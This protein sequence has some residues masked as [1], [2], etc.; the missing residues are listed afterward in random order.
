MID[1]NGS[2]GQ[3][4]LVNLLTRARIT[5]KSLADSVGIREATVSDWKNRG[6][7]PS[8]TPSQLWLMKRALNATDEELIEA[9]EGF[10]V[11]QSLLSQ[12]N[13]SVESHK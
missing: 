4:T 2:K 13:D 11:L 8:L 6:I 1:P 5:Q 3:L 12:S 9:F 7:I 10:D